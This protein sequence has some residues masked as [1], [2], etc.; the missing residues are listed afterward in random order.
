MGDQEVG[1]NWALRTVIA[2]WPVPVEGWTFYVTS[3]YMNYHVHAEDEPRGKRVRITLTKERVYR[4][5]EMFV[6]HLMHKEAKKI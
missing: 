3:D 6:S 4:K 5:D 1:S 2:Y